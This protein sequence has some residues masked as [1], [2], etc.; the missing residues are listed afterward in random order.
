[1]RALTLYALVHT[2][3]TRD[4]PG[5]YAAACAR[6]LPPA[7]SEERET[8]EVMFDRIHTANLDVQRR[9]LDV[10]A[11]RPADARRPSGRRSRR[12]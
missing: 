2:P 10:Q 1:V 8:L 4:F 6:W 5:A 3:R 11:K 7:E 9:K 12:R